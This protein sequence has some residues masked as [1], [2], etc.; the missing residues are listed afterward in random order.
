MDDTTII[1]ALREILREDSEHYCKAQQSAS[2]APADFR[3]ALFIQDLAKPLA[4]VLSKQPEFAAGGFMVHHPDG[5]ASGFQTSR[6]ATALLRR[7]R[8]G[9]N[10][11]KAVE[12]LDKVI[13][14]ERAD[15]LCVMALWGVSVNERVQLGRSVD[16]V[17]LEQLPPSQYKE[18]LLSPV[19]LEVIK[20]AFAAPWML[21]R[22]KVALTVSDCVD[23]FITKVKADDGSSTN[24]PLRYHDLLDDVRLALTCVG[25]CAPLQAV[26]WFQYADA[27]FEE[28]I[29]HWTS[30]TVHEIPPSGF[31]PEVT[32]NA[33]DAR[34]V[35]AGF[36]ALSGQPLARVRVSLQRLNQALRRRAVGDCALELSIALEALLS[37][38]SQGEHTYKVALRAALL[39]GGDLERR[40]E[41]RAII[42]AVY[43]LR[44]ALVHR[45]TA[46]EMVKV[47]SKGQLPAKEVVKQG[48]SITA[49]VIREVIRR[50]EIPDWN[51]LELNP[52]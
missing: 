18:R 51:A 41:S 27:D 1:T 21:N 9:E 52:V 42:H 5:G 28:A 43:G 29:H 46:P 23:P 34:A 4:E 13:T 36:F 48:A 12:W 14:T 11:Q 32:I 49:T 40:A 31:E 6:A 16:L 20:F 3:E 2:Q 19:D 37:D 25:P 35:L 39:S 47:R 45:G 17:P 15:V 30:S 38:G 10:P 33:A 7:V 26:S 8:K 50:G 44:S 24:E 22:P